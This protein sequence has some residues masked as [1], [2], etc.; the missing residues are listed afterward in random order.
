MLYDMFLPICMFSS[1]VGIVNEE[2]EFYIVHRGT[3]AISKSCVTKLNCRNYFDVLMV[4]GELQIHTIS[5]ESIIDLVNI[6]L[7]FLYRTNRT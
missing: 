6:M 3:P 7:Q 5:T 2:N 1:S 4:W